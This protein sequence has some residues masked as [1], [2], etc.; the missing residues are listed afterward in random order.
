MKIW[1]RNFDAIWIPVRGTFNVQSKQ[2]Y[3][4]SSTILK[5]CL[6]QFDAGSRYINGEEFASVGRLKGN[7][8]SA[9][10][11]REVCLIVV[12]LV[13]FHGDKA[14]CL[15]LS[16]INLSHLRSSFSSSDCMLR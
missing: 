16:K 12:D 8:N 7:C 10:S 14:V 13:L 9:T 4:L 15:R 5:R 6:R 11:I 2:D 1:T 3:Y